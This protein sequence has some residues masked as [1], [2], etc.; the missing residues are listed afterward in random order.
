MRFGVLG[1]LLLC[2]CQVVGPRPPM[3][4]DGMPPKEIN[5]AEFLLVKGEVL[6]QQVAVVRSS[7]DVRDVTVGDVSAPFIRRA[8]DQVILQGPEG[9]VAAPMN[10]LTAVT[11]TGPNVRR[12]VVGRRAT[13]WGAVGGATVGGAVLA[14]VVLQGDLD[15]PR[16]LPQVVTLGPLLVGGYA[17][18]GAGVGF[19]VGHLGSGDV[20]L[21]T[22]Q[23]WVPVVPPKK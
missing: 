10:E 14:I 8:G 5:R 2:A 1:L 17:I 12:W 19:V 11:F 7:R 3:V 6:E 16:D 20:T 21:S 18:V 22:D 4:Y 23:G 9:P 15:L 13:T